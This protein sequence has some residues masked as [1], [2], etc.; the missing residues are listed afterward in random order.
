VFPEMEIDLAKSIQELR[1]LG[2]PVETYMV[3]EEARNIHRKTYPT[4]WTTL[5]EPF[6]FSNNWMSA[7]FCR[8]GFSR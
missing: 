4:L 5:T 8:F 7:F 2:I 6:K 1:D 3:Q